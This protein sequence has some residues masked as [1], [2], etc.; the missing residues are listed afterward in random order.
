[1]QALTDS[2]VFMTPPLRCA[3]VSGTYVLFRFAATDPTQELFTAEDV[4]TTTTGTSTR[5]GT[6]CTTFYQLGGDWEE[7]ASILFVMWNGAFT[8]EHFTSCAMQSYPTMRYMLWTYNFIFSLTTAVLLLNMLIAM[9][10]KTIDN[11]WEASSTHAQ[12]LYA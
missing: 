9:M 3:L 11:V 7:W 2:T 1:M 5:R 12:F 8:E 10:G 4:E 6:A